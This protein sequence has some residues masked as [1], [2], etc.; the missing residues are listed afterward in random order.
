MAVLMSWI[1]ELPF[2][3]THSFKSGLVMDLAL[4][5]QCIHTQSVAVL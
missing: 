4:S 5:S 1:W 2:V 3:R